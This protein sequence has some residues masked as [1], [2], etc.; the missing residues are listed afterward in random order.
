MA[1]ATTTLVMWIIPGLVMAVIVA[2][3]MRTACVDRGR[4]SGARMRRL[5]NERGPYETADALNVAGISPN[6]RWLLGE[7]QQ[8]SAGG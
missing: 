4:G 6:L 7:Q 5:L 3:N 2:P 8:V 1:R